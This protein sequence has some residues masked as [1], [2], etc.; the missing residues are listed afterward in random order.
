[1]QNQQFDFFFTS[2]TN[3]YEHFETS[4]YEALVG[5][6]RSA[7]ESAKREL[8]QCKIKVEGLS[9]DVKSFLLVLFFEFFI[10]LRETTIKLAAKDERINELKHEIDSLKKEHELTDQTN[11]QLHL[12]VRELESNIGSYDSVANKSSLTISSLQK[13]AK[14]R[15]EQLMELQSRVR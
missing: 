11:N 14:E 3:K 12:R 10:Q 6:E 2:D 1:M 15:Q 13:D 9:H 8:D 5:Q 7:F 4:K